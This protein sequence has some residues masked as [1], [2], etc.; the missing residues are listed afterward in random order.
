MS[1]EQ[2]EHAWKING[3]LYLAEGCI[4]RAGD[5]YDLLTYSPD[6][7]I[8]CLPSEEKISYRCEEKHSGAEI[9]RITEGQNYTEY[10]M[11]IQYPDKDFPENYWLIIGFDGDRAELWMDG[12]LCGDWFYTGNDWQIGLKYFNWPKQMTIRIYPVREHVYVEK[13]PEQRCGI[14][15]IHVQ[16]EYRISLGTLE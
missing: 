5:K 12:E 7:Q 3:K 15:K 14:R 2:A 8:C 9:S 6:G 10:E 4:C 1:R 16:T 13:K 11:N